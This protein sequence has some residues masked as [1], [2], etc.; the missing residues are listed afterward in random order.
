MARAL[1][2]DPAVFLLDEPLSNLDVRLRGEIRSL[3]QSLGL[4]TFM[5][6]HDQPEAPTTSDRLVAM[7]ACRLRQ[8]GTAEDHCE[9]PADA[10]AADFVGR[11]NP[12]RGAREEGGLRAAPGLLLDRPADAQGAV[13]ALRPEPIAIAASETGPG[14]AAVIGEALSLCAQTE[15]AVDLGAES[16]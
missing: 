1:A 14:R 4:T 7:Q 2:V 5:V 16:A 6:T 13:V 10:F 11:P 3:R 15:C 8:T 9:R 12:V